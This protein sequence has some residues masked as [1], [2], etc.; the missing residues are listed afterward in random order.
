MKNVGEQVNALI[1]FDINSSSDFNVQRVSVCQLDSLPHPPFEIT[2][3]RLLLSSIRG[4]TSHVKIQSTRI[5]RADIVQWSIDHFQMLS[6]W[7]LSYEIVVC[8]T[9]PAQT[10][11]TFQRRGM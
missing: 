5:D 8:G 2:R 10:L 7:K 11:Q 3:E 9:L 1:L 4:N 6:C